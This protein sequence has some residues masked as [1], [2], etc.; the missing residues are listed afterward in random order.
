MMAH[1]MHHSSFLGTFGD[2]LK[3]KNGL[4]ITQS[5]RTPVPSTVN[6]IERDNGSDNGAYAAL[7]S[8]AEALRDSFRRDVLALK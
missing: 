5:L 8:Q 7:S 3:V 2:P 4:F 6:V 1:E